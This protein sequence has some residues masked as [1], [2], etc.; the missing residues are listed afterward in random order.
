MYLAS[1]YITLCDIQKYFS[2]SGMSADR[3]SLHFVIKK[4][5][6]QFRVEHRY[7][8]KSKFSLLIPIN[9]VNILRNFTE[10]L[11]LE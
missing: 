2:H 5:L 3:D 11:S 8:C 1:S 9:I 10:K 6:P 4:S 7:I